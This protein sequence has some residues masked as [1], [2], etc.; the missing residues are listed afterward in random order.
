MKRLDISLLIIFTIF[1]LTKAQQ[2]GQFCQKKIKLSILDVNEKDTFYFKN[3][4]GNNYIIGTQNSATLFRVSNFNA[5][6]NIDLNLE[7]Y[8]SLPNNYFAYSD[9]FG[10]FNPIFGFDN[11]NNPTKIKYIVTEDST[12]ENEYTHALL[13]VEKNILRKGRLSDGYPDFKIL[14]A[15][16]ENE[17]IGA[18][19]LTDAGTNTYSIRLQ[20]MS[21]NEIDKGNIKVL[22]AKEYFS[23]VNERHNINNIFYLKNLKKIM[24]VR[25]YGKNIYLDFIDYLDNS[26]GSV[27]TAEKI[28]VD[29][30]ISEYKF[31]TMEL[32]TEGDKTHFI[33]CFRKYNF[34]YCFTGY[35]D[36]VLNKF[37]FTQKKPKLMISSCDNAKRPDLNIL[38]MDTET[39][40][41]G[42][43]GEPYIA[44]KFG[45]DLNKIGTEI[46]FPKPYSE[47]T[48]INNYT[49]FF[50]YRDKETNDNKY[51]LYGCAYYL[52]VCKDNKVFFKLQETPHDLKEYLYN[53]KELKFMDNINVL[54]F[55]GKDKDASLNGLSNGIYKRSEFTYKN[56]LE[57]FEDVILFQ[58]VV[59]PGTYASY[60]EKCTLKIINCYKSCNECDNVGNENEHNCLSCNPDYNFVDDPS[61]K[62]CIK[63][64]DFYYQDTVDHYYKRCYESCKTCDNAG[65][66]NAHN[67]NLCYGQKHYYKIDKIDSSSPFNCYLDLLPPDGYYFNK[68]AT[69]TN[70][71]SYFLSCG[72]GCLRCNPDLKKSN[73][74]YSCIMCN[75]RQGYYPLFQDED[76]NN[77]AKCLNKDTEFPVGHIIDYSA[78]R[79][80]I[81]Y[82]SCLECEHGGNDEI[83]NCTKCNPNFK[84]YTV[85]PSTCKC[86][87]NFY[88]ELDANNKPQSLKCTDDLSCPNDYPYLLINSQNLRQCLKSCPQESPYIYNN[89]C[90]DHKLNG[91]SYEDGNFQGSDNNTINTDNTQC[92]INDY[93][94]STI[95]KDDVPKAKN[96]YVLNYI[97]EYSSSDGYDY[98]YNHAN[99]IRSNNEDYILLIFQNENCLKKIKDEYGLSFVDLT[100]Y[101][102]DIKN[103]NNI[104]EDEPL[105]YAFLYTDPDDPDAEYQNIDYDCFDSNNASIL[106]LTDTLQGKNIT[107]NNALPGGDKLKKL[108]NLAKYADL[109]IDFSDPNSEFF[110]SQCFQFSTDEGKDVTLADRRKYFFNKIKICEDECVFSGIDEETKTAKCICPYDKSDVVINKNVEFPDYDEDYFIH[111]MW[112]CLKKDMVSPKQL[113]KSYITI[114]TFCLFIAAIA[115]TVLYFVFLKNKFQ[116]LSKITNNNKAFNTNDNTKNLYQSV[117]N[118]DK[119]TE[120]IKT[121]KYKRISKNMISNP[122]PKNEVEKSSDST[123][124]KEKG[125][126]QDT[127]KPFHYDNNNLFYHGEENYISGKQNLNSLF[128]GQNFKNNYSREIAQFEN[129]EK[130]PKEIINN[131]NNVPIPSKRSSKKN[132]PTRINNFNNINYS[133]NLF[134][135]NEEALN[136]LPKNSNVKNTLIFPRND[137]SDGNSTDPLRSEGNKKKF[138][139][140][141]EKNSIDIIQEKNYEEKFD[142]VL[143]KAKDEVGEENMELNILDYNTAKKNDQRSFCYFY[144]NQLKHRQIFL[145]TGYFHSLAEGLFMKILVV[146]FH[147]LICLFLNLFWYRTSYVHDEFISSI[148]NHATFSSRYGWFRILLSVVC[149]IIIIC[150]FHLIYLPQLKIYY[151]LIDEKIELNKKKE[152]IKNK[153]KCMKLNYLI[154]SII[155]LCFIIVLIIYVLV[156]SYVFINS[157][158][159]LMISFI[160]TFILTQALPFIFVFLVTCFR[161]YGLKYNSPCAFK[162][163]LFFTI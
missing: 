62:M 107:K 89:Q 139:V 113:K 104:G 23:V 99:L 128:M 85:N 131:Y 145:Y 158:T 48:V 105:T 50:T 22:H 3:V 71:Q 18:V 15:L 52:P 114:I 66:I 130:K 28:V 136:Q 40:I 147:I 4:Y 137:F 101:S 69:D 84:Q 103:D 95:P 67:C 146:L 154:F 112:K 96:D 78:G 159:D 64:S 141:L 29:F 162:F 116:A 63:K 160:L 115:F 38:K 150:L 65:T 86:E 148:N 135:I 55:I 134:K 156:F 16:N 74:E 76:S 90:F 35:F 94:K 87:Y 111:D 12:A 149:Y 152:I 13:D 108:E 77:Y 21:F 44:M 27:Y 31:N 68:D 153:I 54:S 46:I 98:T 61:S 102:K 151:S 1:Y 110:N 7:Q 59:N 39:I 79:Y 109:G 163:S 119:S 91:T 53:D 82:P 36:K 118:N 92:I 140:P 42:C 126:I 83:H 20:I 155:N 37:I 2:T 34:V 17:Y 43:P 33:S 120:R 19:K 125:F 80:S 8:E 142:D 58:A 97:N 30:D 5:D 11:M 70:D 124:T 93:I 24:L 117:K 9:V 106:N 41:I 75:T 10:N 73:A 133:S 161:F 32:K 127:K 129:D 132:K 51:Y 26:F 138:K 123:N 47:F 14:E 122:P 144:F 25:T 49:L 56:T 157:K 45:S 88:Y 100:E 143:K 72:S 60:S 121:L 81:C 6:Q 57:S